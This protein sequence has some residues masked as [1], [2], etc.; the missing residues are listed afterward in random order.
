VTDKIRRYYVSKRSRDRDVETDITFLKISWALP[1]S[2]KE[3]Q[4]RYSVAELE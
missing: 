1:I 4:G 2:S 3:R